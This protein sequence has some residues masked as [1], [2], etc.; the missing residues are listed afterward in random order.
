MWDLGQITAY[1]KYSV[2]T[3]LVTSESVEILC[4]LIML[5]PQAHNALDLKEMKKESVKKVLKRYQLL[6]WNILILLTQR[7]SLEKHLSN[8]VYNSED[9][10]I[11]SSFTKSKFRTARSKF[12]LV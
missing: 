11:G 1:E 9:K 2:F 7:L 12:N 8:T 5:N 4:L 10:V 3:Y 6:S